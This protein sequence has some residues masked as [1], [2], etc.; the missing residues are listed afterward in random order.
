[1]GRFANI[2]VNTLNPRVEQSNL[3]KNITYGTFVTNG[4]VT[5]ENLFVF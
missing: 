2:S 1:M 5:M 4:K 3:G